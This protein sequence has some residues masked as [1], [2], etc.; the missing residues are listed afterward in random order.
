MHGGAG[1]NNMVQAKW[2]LYPNTGIVQFVRGSPEEPLGS[3]W[4]QA[5]DWRSGGQAAEWSCFTRV[6]FPFMGSRRITM[7]SMPVINR[8]D[9][10]LSD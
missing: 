6:S 4:G 5:A 10:V 9:N 7:L 2:D 1:K 8:G 3:T